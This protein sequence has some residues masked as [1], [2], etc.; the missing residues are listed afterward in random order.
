M[1][2]TITDQAMI[3]VATAGFPVGSITDRE[4]AYLET[5]SAGAK[6]FADKSLA[7]GRK[8]TPVSPSYA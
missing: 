7:L 6:S 2:L 3:D 5:K 8:R 4:T 1:A